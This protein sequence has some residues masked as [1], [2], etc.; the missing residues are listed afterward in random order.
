MKWKT[1]RF[2]S[3]R[4]AQFSHNMSCYKSREIF[5]Y[6]V[7][8]ISAECFN[9]Y[10]IRKYFLNQVGKILYEIK[11]SFRVRVFFYTSSSLL[12]LLQQHH[13]KCEMIKCDALILHSATAKNSSSLNTHEIPKRQGDV[14]YVL[15]FN[16]STFPAIR[17]SEFSQKSYSINWNWSTAREKRNSE[18]FLFARCGYREMAFGTEGD[19]NTNNLAISCNCM[20][21]TEYFSLLPISVFFLASINF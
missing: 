8:E 7:R 20:W 6:V 1:I 11:Y 9:Q 21:M 3:L 19:K 16:W 2:K 18:C 12:L 15:K 10:F 4:L 17:F 5:L 14:L 13:I